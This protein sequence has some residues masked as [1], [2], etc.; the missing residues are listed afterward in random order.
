MGKII[1]HHTQESAIGLSPED[2]K[3]YAG[4]YVCFPSFSDR[5]V[6]SAHIEVKK[7]REM[8]EEKGFK[9]PVAFYIPFPNERLTPLEIGLRFFLNGL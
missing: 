2:Q 8:A 4:Q 9:N 7:A 5:R 3:K 6:I 1:E